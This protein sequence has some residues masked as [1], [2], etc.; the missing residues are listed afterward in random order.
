MRL[1]TFL[2]LLLSFLMRSQDTLFLR[3]GTTTVAKVLEVSVNEV[4]YKNPA[5]PDGP[6]YTIYK[7]DIRKI[8]YGSGQTELFQEEQQTAK[9]PLPVDKIIIEGNTFRY[10]DGKRLPRSI[11]LDRAEEKSKRLNLPDLSMHVKRTRKDHRIKRL[12]LFSG[13]AFLAAGLGGAFGGAVSSSVGDTSDGP[14]LLE[15][16]GASLLTG[17]GLTLLSNRFHKKFRKDALKTA[18]AYNND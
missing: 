7:S 17:T 18:E 10:P 14:V 12:F 6:L 13:I 16:S 9:N 11:M 15:V 5:L 4:K 3:D 2:F 8:K 1:L